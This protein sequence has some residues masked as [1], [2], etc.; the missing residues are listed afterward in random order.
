MEA[1]GQCDLTINGEK[2]SVSPLRL[3]EWFLLQQK[4]KS[5]KEAVEQGNTLRICQKIISFV[6]TASGFSEESIA[7]ENWIIVCSAYFQ[8]YN[9]NIPDTEL[10]FIKFS[11]GRDREYPWDY[12]GRDWWYFCHLLA[13][14]YQWSVEYISNLDVNEAFS[15]I[16]EILVEDQLQKEWE[17]GLSEKSIEYNPKTKTSKFRE[18][19][20]PKWMMEDFKPA[21]MMVIPIDMLPVGN[22]KDFTQ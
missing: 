5:L 14:Q 10:P 9:I 15:L 18:L 13:S 17:W 22:I 2:K 6:S 8:L 20:R 4:R 16:Q 12:E 3:R 1:M 21:P 7:D 11:G 19:D